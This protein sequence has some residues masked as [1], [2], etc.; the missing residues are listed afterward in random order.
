MTKIK[1]NAD[2]RLRCKRWLP[3]MENQVNIRELYTQVPFYNANK[4]GSNVHVSY[5]L[6]LQDKK[7]FI[8]VRS[9]E[10]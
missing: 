9:K 6:R 8:I 5:I 4:L 3:K 1:A 2:K 10:S 7:V